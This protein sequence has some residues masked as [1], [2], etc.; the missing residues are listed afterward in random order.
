MYRQTSN[1]MRTLI[2][3]G[4]VDNSDVVEASPVGVAPTKSSIST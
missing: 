4:I 2:D 3:N 1:I